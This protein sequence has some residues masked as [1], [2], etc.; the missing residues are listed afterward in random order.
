MSEREKGLASYTTEE[1]EA[2]V[3]ERKEQELSEEVCLNE[4]V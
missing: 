4:E 2:E 3:A 1:L